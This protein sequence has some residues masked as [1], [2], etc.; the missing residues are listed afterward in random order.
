VTPPL[1]TAPTAP[2]ARALGLDA[3]ADLARALADAPERWADRVRHLPER[4]C[5]ERLWRD[6]AVDVWVICWMDDHDTGFHDH[7]VSAGAVAVVRGA[8][9]E[10]RI[11]LGGAPRARIVRGGETI[12][13]DA[14]HVHRMRHAGGEPAVSIHV[15]SPPLARMGVYSVEEDG[16]LRRETVPYDEELGA[17]RTEVVPTTG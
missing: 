1:P 4:R 12:A 10:E 16:S 2:P 3:L 11:A 7:D 9:L 17:E 13:F 15:Y 5:Y 6:E 8:L 14:A